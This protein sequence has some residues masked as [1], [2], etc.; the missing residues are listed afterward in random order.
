MIQPHLLTRLITHF[1]EEIKGK[2][3]FLTPGMPRFKIERSRINM[4]VLDTQSQR[5]Y[6]FGV[7]MSCNL[8]K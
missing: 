3:K 2:R 7:G 1:G 8:T 5:K 6:R 4:Y